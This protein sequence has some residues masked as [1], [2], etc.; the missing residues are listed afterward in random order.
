MK[1]MYFAG[2]LVLVLGSSVW[3][4]EQQEPALS[5]EQQEYMEWAMALWQTLS[6]QNGEVAL[7]S[8]A[9][10]LNVPDDFYF[11][12]PEDA[13]T[14]LVDVWG[15]PPGQ[16]VL[17]MLF[18]AEYTPFES[19]AWAVIIQ[20]AEE[21]YVSD[22][23]AGSINYDKLLRQ[24][25]KDTRDTSNERVKEGY[26]A[27]ELVGWAAAPYYDPTQNKLHW[28]KELKFGD[29]EEN[30]LN[31][32][33]RVLGRKG[34]LVL[35]FVANMDQQSLIEQRLDAVL[36]MA[37]FNEGARYA[38]FQ[39]G[40][41]TVAAYGIGALVAGKVASKAGLLAAAMLFLK[42]FWIFIAIG[43]L[44]LFKKLFSRSKSAAEQ[45]AGE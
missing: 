42:K 29:A 34:M 7:D 43:I 25:Q 28:A 12:S 16:E 31:Y 32:N 19:E 39:P 21:G 4:S 35:N 33:I 27:I 23:D 18:P 30:T 1:G 24:M 37:E 44:A 40:I 2:I 26:E 15:N 5:A 45:P 13:H 3:A 6:P 14:V 9:V 38:D 36:A 8:A 41:D 22:E 20:Y 11:L 17:G 10:T